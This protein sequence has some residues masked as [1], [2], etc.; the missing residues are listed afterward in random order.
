M[1]F[2]ELAQKIGNFLDEK[3]RI[4]GN[5]YNFT[6]EYL[7]TKY[8]EGIPPEVIDSILAEIRIVEKLSRMVS[9]K[10]N[11]TKLDEKD[12]PWWDIVGLA[13]LQLKRESE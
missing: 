12:N 11:G 3:E 9:A 4:H 6:T 8:P 1:T 7:K 13:L 10:T 5:S 2:T